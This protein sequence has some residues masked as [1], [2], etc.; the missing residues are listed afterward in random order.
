MHARYCFRL[1]A[2]LLLMIGAPA[3]ASGMMPPSRPAPPAS[4]ILPVLVQVDALGKVVNVTPSEELGAPML[5]LVKQ[6]LDA[7]ITRPAH[8][9]H[10]HAVA[11]RLIVRLAVNAAPAADGTYRVQLSYVSARAVPAGQW[12][13]VHTGDKVA[14]TRADA[15]DRNRERPTA[16]ECVNPGG[17]GAVHRGVFFINGV[18][19]FEGDPCKR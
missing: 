10:G 11:S 15:F 16:T 18:A 17:G 13:W 4:R 6:T 1:A 9:R 5:A 7:L 19:H 14:L 2:W 12:R 8:D 3:F